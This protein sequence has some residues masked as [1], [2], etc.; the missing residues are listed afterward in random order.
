M[1]DREVK[2]SWQVAYQQDRLPFIQKGWV[3]PAERMIETDP[4]ILMAEDW[5]KRG[6]FADHPHRGFQTVTYLL[7]GQLEH[8]DNSGGHTILEPGDMQYMNAGWAA[9]HAEEAVG[10]GI[11]HTLQLWLNLP[12][13]LKKSETSYQNVYS[14]EAEVTSLPGGP[15]R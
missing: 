8:V 9:R 15:G 10:E 1:S 5:F 2:E 7:D 3:I 6:A 11:A 12:A 4:F 13:A 14:E